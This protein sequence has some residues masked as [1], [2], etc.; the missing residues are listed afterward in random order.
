MK[1]SPDG[2]RVAYGRVADGDID[3]EL[4]VSDLTRQTATRLTFLRGIAG[5]PSWS[6]DASA[7]AFTSGAAAGVAGRRS[8]KIVAASGGT[9]REVVLPPGAP[10]MSDWTPNGEFLLFHSAG[11]ELWE[12]RPDGSRPRSLLKP[13]A[14]R[15]DQ[16][17][18]S[19]DG[20]WLAFSMEESGR[21]E[22]YVTPFPPGGPRWQVSTDGGVQP[23]WSRAGGELFFLGNDGTLRAAAVKRVAAGLEFGR[24][25]PLFRIGFAP[26]FG[27]E[28]YDVMPDGQTFV[29]MQPRDE[30][31]ARSVITI[32]LNAIGE[33]PSQK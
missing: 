32:W 31:R 1:V 20:K 15:I 19:P 23:R 30:G 21:P 16:A 10:Y 22:I 4:W 8:L 25:D 14:G 2:T 11:L 33:S 18:V 6:P 26:S 27:I 28:Q 7:I 12:V 17:S 9:P 5:D 13:A 24:A 29:V 3:Q